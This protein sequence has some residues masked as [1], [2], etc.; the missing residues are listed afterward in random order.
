MTTEQTRKLHAKAVAN[1]D[2]DL[3]LHVQLA[4]LECYSELADELLGEDD[5]AT[6]TYGRQETLPIAA[7]DIDIE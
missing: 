5:F 7:K 6:C 4:A 3:L 2:S 1:G